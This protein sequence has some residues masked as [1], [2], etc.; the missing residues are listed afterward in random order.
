M[1]FTP[2]DIINLVKASP[3]FIIALGTAIA[4]VIAALR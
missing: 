1:R 2:R 3:G 4:T